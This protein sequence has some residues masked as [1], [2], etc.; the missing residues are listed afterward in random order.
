MLYRC[1]GTQRYAERAW[2]E[3]RAAAEF[4]DWFPKHF[5]GTAEM[6]HACA[7]GYDWLYDVLTTKQRAVLRDAVLEKGLAPALEAYQHQKS[8][9]SWVYA[10]NNWNLVCNSGIGLG[11]L[12]IKDEASG[13][14][15]RIE[16]FLQSALG[17]LEN[18]MPRFAPDGGW[19]E[20]LTY[21]SYGTYYVTLFLA[22]LERVRG[23]ENR[24]SRS[25]GFSETGFFPMYLT[26]PTASTFN[27]SDAAP[28]LPPSPQLFWHSKRFDHPALDWY[29]HR[30][31]LSNRAPHA[32]N[33]LWYAPPAAN[34]QEE[35]LPLDRHFRG[36]GVVALRSSWEDPEAV[37][38]GFKAG[39]NRASHGHLDQGSFVLDALGK[40]WVPDL[41]AMDYDVPGYEDDRPAGR[42]WTYYRVRAEGHNTLVINPDGEPDQN[43]ASVSRILLFRAEPERTFA[44]ADLTPAYGRDT[45]KV[46]RGISLLNRWQVLVQDEVEA[47]DQAQL[48]WFMHTGSEEIELEPDGAGAVLKQGRARLWVRILSPRWASFE[49]M[50]ARPLPTSPDPTVQGQNEGVRKLGIRLDNVMNLQLAVLLVPLREVDTPPS[51]LPE[52]QP[53]AEWKLRGAVPVVPATKVSPRH[54]G[55]VGLDHTPWRS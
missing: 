16:E 21:W 35:N 43:P 19:E 37:F 36:T 3:L 44:I 12:A 11:A 25:P 46:W 54:G 45:H 39:D 40:R 31:G 1:D 20:G 51:D 14:A 55:P 50:D 42:R 15:E 9:G 32:L 26:G 41:G 52:V 4:P 7:I 28:L 18:A 34:P 2:E 5:L 6:S 23:A 30:F 27:F 22:A 53:L 13:S 24:L 29:Q 38:V 49:I 48:W 8:E 17:S 47:V 33:L 10:T